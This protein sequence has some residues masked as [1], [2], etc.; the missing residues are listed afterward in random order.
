MVRLPVVSRRRCRRSRA[1][2]TRGCRWLVGLRIAPRRA[3]PLVVREAFR[4]RT[5]RWV[6]E[7]ICGTRATCPGQRLVA[8]TAAAGRRTAEACWPCLE[9]IRRAR[10]TR[11]AYVPSSAARIDGVRDPLL[12]RCR[13]AHPPRP[14]RLR[15]RAWGAVASLSPELFS[16]A[17]RRLGR[18]ESDQGHAAAARES[19]IPA[20]LGQGRRGER[21]D[22]R[23]CPQRS[24]PGRG[25]RSVIGPR[26]LL[27]ASGPGGLAS[28]LYGHDRLEPTPPSRPCWRPPSR[29]PRSGL[30]EASGPPAALPLG[31]APS[32]GVLRHSRVGLTRSPAP[33]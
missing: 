24:R 32:R 23:P 12:R 4:C 3:R 10:F 31:A 2:H 26:L 20:C 33:S 6:T 11:L 5:T 28:G 18:V 14:R 15:G 8:G 25:Y 9:A 1:T 22:R 30:A 29:P 27:G 19:G 13:D 7:A 17:P 21:H 16:P